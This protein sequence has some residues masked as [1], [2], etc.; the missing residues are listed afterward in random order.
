MLYVV[1]TPI[2]NLEDITVRAQRILTESTSILCEDPRITKKLCNLLGIDTKPQFIALSRNKEINYSGI[3]K[4]L[5][6]ISD[7]DVVSLV[8]D[9]GTPGMSDPGC[10]IVR[11]CQELG[12][13]YTVLPGATAFVPALVASGIVQKEFVFMGFLPTKKGR[14]TAW[15]TISLSHYPVVFYE[16]VHRIAKCILEAQ[17]YLQPDQKISISREISKT[18]E[19]LWSGKVSDLSSYSLVEKGEFVVV[20]GENKN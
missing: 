17:E 8:T 18:F 20:V 16:S 15:A 13:K 12:I 6:T 11:M 19:S 1:P 9:A 10:E 5:D 14:K 2:G 7:N 3:A 4:V